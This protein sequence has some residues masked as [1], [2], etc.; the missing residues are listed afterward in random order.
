MKVAITGATGFVGWHTRCAARARWDTDLALI[1]RG[2]FTHP[3]RMDVVLGGADVVIHLAGMNRG[4]PDLIAHE[5]PWLAEQLVASMK[6]LDRRIPVV[7]G[8]SIH[9]TGDS[10]FGLSKRRAADVL[11]AAGLPLANVQ[12][13]NLFGEHGLPDYNS[14]VATFA[15]RLAAGADPV[16][17]DDRYLPL[18]HVQDMA[19]LLLDQATEVFRDGCMNLQLAGARIRV[20]D[21][22]G[23]M[24]RIAEDYR[25]GILPDL[26]DTFTSDLFNTYR[27]ALTDQQRLIRQAQYSDERGHLVESVRARG[28]EAQVFFSETKPGITR[29]QHWHRRKMERFMVLRG[30]A[31]IE[32]RRM[33][34]KE[35]AVFE[36]SGEHPTVVDMPTM[37][38]HKITN[39]GDS[40]LLTLFY[41]NELLDPNRPDTHPEVV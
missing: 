12:M 35:R 22:L 14:V 3:D 27:S 26:S 9:S 41:A 16:I 17:H 18:V 23:R 20:S 13:P 5:N 34:T 15:H 28:G 40:D 2:H 30:E 6:R 32:M 4:D 25:V 31:R 11:A 38:A 36:V 24:T 33:F 29:G 19:D 10:V 21:L 39:V 7:Y 37:W 1:T 8:N